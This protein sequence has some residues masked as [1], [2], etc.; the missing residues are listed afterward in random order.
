MDERL[1]NKNVNS[2]RSIVNGEGLICHE[3]PDDNMLSQCKELGKQLAAL[4]K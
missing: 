3:A 4:Q 1:G 2:R